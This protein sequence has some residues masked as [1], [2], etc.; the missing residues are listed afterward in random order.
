[1][2]KNLLTTKQIALAAVFA[3]LHAVLGLLPYTIT[4]GVSGQI[5]L[6]VIGGPLIG[7]VLGPFLGGFAVLFGL[8][9]VQPMQFQPQRAWL[10]SVLF[11]RSVLFGDRN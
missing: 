7:I 5:T 4:I 11:A 2:S 10:L 9:Q 8:F 3:A 6:G 1:M